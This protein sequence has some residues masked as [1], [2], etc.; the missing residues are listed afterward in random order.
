MTEISLLDEGKH[1][2]K[3]WDI[4]VSPFTSGP[5][6]HAEN[7]PNR[8]RV[9]NTLIMERN[10]AI[11]AIEGKGKERHITIKFYDEKGKEINKFII[12]QD[13]YNNSYGRKRH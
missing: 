13:A 9:K 10:F 12:K 1:F 7:E 11:F 6:T 8:L 2:P 4:T 5:N 3:I